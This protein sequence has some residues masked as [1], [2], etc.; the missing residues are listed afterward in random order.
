MGVNVKLPIGVVNGRFWRWVEAVVYGAMSTTSCGIHHKSFSTTN[1]MS[2]AEC[3]FSLLLSVH[4]SNFVVST[5]RTTCCFWWC[6]AITD[7]TLVESSPTAGRYG[8]GLFAAGHCFKQP[9]SGF[10]HKSLHRLLTFQRKKGF[11][12]QVYK[13]CTHCLV[14]TLERRGLNHLSLPSPL[15]NCLRHKTWL[16]LKGE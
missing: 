9:L 16:V 4:G 2:F 12:A 15:V 13:L 3:C 7:S 11:M 5:Y 10:P 8:P 14:Y 6:T 1:W